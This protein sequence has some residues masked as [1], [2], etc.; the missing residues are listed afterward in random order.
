MKTIDTLLYYFI[1]ILNTTEVR[2]KLA[3]YEMQL[4]P[5]VGDI[6]SIVQQSGLTVV[7]LLPE[8]VY[9]RN[10]S[11]ATLFDMLQVKTILNIDTREIVRVIDAASKNSPSNTM[12]SSK[13]DA[14][15]RNANEAASRRTLNETYL[16]RAMRI[17]KALNLSLLF[18]F[19][20]RAFF[21]FFFTLL[22][23]LK[24]VF[25]FNLRKVSKQYFGLFNYN[26][27]KFFGIALFKNTF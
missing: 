19:K 5:D 21:A 10:V 23:M 18:F 22:S 6:Y 15:A 7:D 9:T 20:V 12:A 13:I 25:F 11:Y 4:E 27:I 24:L 1:Q 2:R 17:R 3:G 26:S 14:T 16:A 8:I